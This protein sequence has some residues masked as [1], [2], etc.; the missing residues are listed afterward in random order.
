[1]RAGSSPVRTAWPTNQIVEFRAWF[2][3]SYRALFNVGCFQRRTEQPFS[4]FTFDILAE[5]HHQLEYVWWCGKISRSSKRPLSVTQDFLSVLPLRR[6]PYTRSQRVSH[7]LTP[8]PKGEKPREFTPHNS[9]SI[10]SCCIM[11]R[12]RGFLQFPRHRLCRKIVSSEILAETLAKK[13]RG[14]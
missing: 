5:P 14:Y 13:C 6:W 9:G 10:Q 8:P 1:M 3:G 4:F 2:N 11:R 7:P 12:V